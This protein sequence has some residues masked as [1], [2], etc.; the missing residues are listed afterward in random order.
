MKPNKNNPKN[1]IVEI[2][3]LFR[4]FILKPPGYLSLAGTTKFL[5]KVFIILILNV[6]MHSDRDFLL[7]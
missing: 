5:N 3:L 6:R 1:N 2:R 4:T 7:T